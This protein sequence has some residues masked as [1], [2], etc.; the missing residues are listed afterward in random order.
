MSWQTVGKAAMRGKK[1][2][3]PHCGGWSFADKNI[4]HHCY[5]GRPWPYKVDGA[6]GADT[7]GKAQGKGKGPSKAELQI[8]EAE[9]AA[10][11]LA[12]KQKAAAKKLAKQAKKTPTADSA[13]MKELE[14]AKAKITALEKN[15]AKE[16]ASKASTQ[17]EEAVIALQLVLPDTPVVEDQYIF[18]KTGMVPLKEPQPAAAWA[19]FPSSLIFTKTPEE[20][21]EESCKATDNVKTLSQAVATAKLDYENAKQMQSSEKTLKMLEKE[22]KDQEELLGAA[23]KKDGSGK[24]LA[25]LRKAEVDLACKEADRV[26]DFQAKQKVARERTQSNIAAM[27]AQIQT[28]MA[29][30]DAYAR[31][32]MEADKAHENRHKLL[33]ERSELRLKALKD[34]MP[35]GQSPQLTAPAASADLAMDLEA[36][37]EVAEADEFFAQVMWSYPELPQVQETTAAEKLVFATLANNLNEWLQFGALRFT[38]A[39]LLNAPV[40]FKESMIA[41]A[42]LLGPIMPRL[43]AGR[44]PTE[45]D[46]VPNAL[47][48]PLHA[49]LMKLD[50]SHIK[51]EAPAKEIITAKGSKTL[52]TLIKKKKEK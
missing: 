3:C 8:A 37:Q 42:K 40:N 16:E 13:I 19:H 22:W 39:Q 47:G 11:K 15:A 25:S 9:A 43:Y 18:K 1:W 35:A 2:T 44:D 28:I 10:K 38:Y 12:K 50:P 7:A 21:V 31:I 49:A 34:R 17:A 52:K 46:T 6:K 41:M 14:A 20:E 33:V 23:Q 32:A 45:T 48:Y 4:C 27:N 24:C 5:A 26:A 30:R 29:R 51:V 36:T